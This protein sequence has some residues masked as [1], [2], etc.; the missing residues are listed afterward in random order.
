MNDLSNVKYDDDFLKLIERPLDDSQYAALST[1]GNTVIAAGAG[2]G[3]TQVL[4][5][6]FAWLVLTGQAEAP[7]ILTLTFTKKAAAEMYQRIYKTLRF[8]AEHQECGELKK[9]HIERA[10]AALAAFADVHIQT[11]DS[12]CTA[13]VRSC[14]NRYGIKPDFNSGSGDGERQVKDSAFK[15]VMQNKDCP[16]IQ[17]F[18]N[19]GKLQ[20]FAEDIIAKI[21]LE[22]TSLA[23]EAGWFSK[24]FEVQ[25]EK[26]A[27]AWNSLVLGKEEGSIYKELEKIETAVQNYELKNPA[28]GRSDSHKA[29]L[30]LINAM[31][32]AYEALAD[33]QKLSIADIKEG[34]QHIKD[35]LALFD[36]FKAAIKAIPSKSGII[37]DINTSVTPFRKKVLD[38]DSIATF[39]RQ[40]DALLD[41][42]RLL[43]EFLEMVNLSKRTSGNL[44]FYDV[45]ELALKILIENED[46][47]EQE[48]NAYKKIMIDEFQDNNGKNRDLL[49]LLAPKDQGKLF[50]VGDEKQS[51]Y[52]FRGADVTVFNKLSSAPENTLVYMT[53]N[54]RSDANLVKAFN[55]IFKNGNGLF[56]SYDQPDKKSNF[57]AYYDKDALKRNK[58]GSDMQLPQLTAENVPIHFCMLDNEKI[59]KNNA[60]LPEKRLNLIPEKEQLAYYIAKKIRELHDQGEGWDKFT[61]LDRSRTNRP[62]LVKYLSLF[63]IPYTVDVYK[64]IFEDGI[65]ND[66][67][68][69]LRLCVYP[70]DVNAFSAWLCSPLAGLKENSLE[71][72]LSHLT[73]KEA[74]EDGYH[75]YTFDIDADVDDKLS[76]DLPEPEFEKYKAAMESFRCLRPRFLTERLTSSLSYLWNDLGYKY[77]SMM[78]EGLLLA[79]EQFD[80]LFEMARQAE[81]NG[82]TLAWFVDQLE[83]VKKNEKK[84][85]DNDSELDAGDITYPLERKESVQIMTIHKSKGL[86]F[87]HV[88]IYGCTDM[89]SKVSSSNF[90][91][92]EES[93]VSIKGE[94]DSGN[95]FFINCREEEKKKELAEIRRVIY[96]AITRAV[97]DVY[98][99]GSLKYKKGSGEIRLIE[100]TVLNFYEKLRQEKIEAEADISSL[101]NPEAGFDLLD[102]P[103]ITYS[104]LPD[105]NSLSI[106]KLRN[107]TE[108]RALPVYEKAAAIEYESKAVLRKTPSSLESQGAGA[109]DGDSGEKYE[110]SADSLRA[111][112]FSAADFGILVHSYLEMQAKGLEADSYE[113]EPKYFKNLSD[114]KIE[115]TKEVCKKLC[116]EFSESQ[117]GQDF[118][119]AKRAGRF[120]R[121]EW[122]FRMFWKSQAAPEGAIF[123]GSIDLIYENADGSYTICDYK[124]DSE[125]DAE[126]YR[127]QQECYRA[128]AGKMLGVSEDKISLRLYFL[129][130]KKIMEL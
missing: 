49:Y 58:D 19:P 79:S 11:L 56:S 30:S 29:Y 4:A 105:R 91:F 51:I 70:S 89:R 112:D 12:Y 43:D 93:G 77:E 20:D 41:F 59:D 121:A 18:A 3:K 48:K 72:I 68:S 88:F 128:A 66:F 8:F 111:A 120:W 96:V 57:E 32:S 130:H 24:K 118:S 83:I 129:K 100:D 69:F 108:E 119:E 16:G 86:Q 40:Y 104:A 45:T 60:E 35:A 103:L 106:E 80:L 67:Y 92:E 78:S 14:A 76:A 10:K 74:S 23:T 115:E 50:F 90:F 126:K 9:N 125:I 28:S 27:E 97:K 34:N 124:S 61:I 81:E 36:S 1:P 102:I 38:Y 94:K 116:L 22:H 13:V 107:K 31:F 62:I 122:G 87:D 71:I 15:F 33:L 52:K 7:Q 64:N 53:Y 17:S 127:G 123:T 44:S 75:K 47:R 55:V 54:Y 117:L 82:K 85:K 46:I 114:E 63:D 25:V 65:V 26:I 84:N 73:V 39:I 110:T 99:I 37:R 2:S 21:I 42:N 113:P 109:E 6:R 98:L 5:T 101:Y 95:F